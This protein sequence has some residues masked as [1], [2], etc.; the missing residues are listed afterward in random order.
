L[1]TIDQL[2]TGGA[3]HITEKKRHGRVQRV[4][5]VQIIAALADAG[6]EL[7]PQGASYGAG[8]RWTAPRERRS[9]N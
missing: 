4:L 3:I 8:V 2:E 1:R 7:L 6:V 9:S 5:W